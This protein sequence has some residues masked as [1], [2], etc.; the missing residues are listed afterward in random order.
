MDNMMLVESN[1][2]VREEKIIANIMNNYFKNITTHFKLEPTKIDPKANLASIINTFQ[3]HKSFHRI[4]FANF[5]LN[6]V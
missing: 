3:K 4:K 5:I 6:L 1:K 2:T